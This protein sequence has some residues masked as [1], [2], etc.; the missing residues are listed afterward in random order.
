MT[1][2]VPTEADFDTAPG[3]LDGAMNL[4]LTTRDCDLG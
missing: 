3:L 2:S 1:Q 4:T